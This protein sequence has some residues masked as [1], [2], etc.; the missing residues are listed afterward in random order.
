MLAAE[1]T[2]AI[3]LPLFNSVC[4]HVHLNGTITVS[5]TEELILS[6]HVDSSVHR[7]GE[8]GAALADF[9]VKGTHATFKAGARI[10]N[11]GDVG[12]HLYL[13][14][15]GSVAVI[16]EDEKGKETA[17]T[18]LFPQDM[19]GEMCLSPSVQSR[20]AT[21]LAREDCE[22]LRIGYKDYLAEASVNPELWM[23]IINQISRQLER[24][25]E[26]VRLLAYCNATQRLANVLRDL[27]ASPSALHN[28]K[29][30]E[31]QIT[32]QDLGSLVGCSREVVSRELQNLRQ[33]GLIDF[34]GRNI[35]ITGLLAV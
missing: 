8:E 12:E 31:L 4:G 1:N 17:L 5:R 35:V 30:T 15:K 25:S 6:K 32:R 18:Y 33:A 21:V 3:E 34:N 27:A 14:L 19:F 28:D 24:C 13:L 29:T 7:L 26:R 22:C 9:P 10:L 11:R 16:I 20:T 23:R 2:N